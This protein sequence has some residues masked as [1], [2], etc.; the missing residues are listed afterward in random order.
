MLSG[1]EFSHVKKHGKRYTPSFFI[2]VSV[3]S[4]FIAH[5]RCVSPWYRMPSCL[6]R[7]CYLWNADDQS[8]TLYFVQQLVQKYNWDM[9]IC[10]TDGGVCKFHQHFFYELIIKTCSVCWN[11][12]NYYAIKNFLKVTGCDGYKKDFFR[13]NADELPVA[14]V[15]LQRNWGLFT[16]YIAAQFLW[17]VSGRVVSCA[18]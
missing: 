7:S 13:E 17:V 4:I 3:A 15:I 9:F 14:D 11:C 2:K 12:Y 1:K 8:S 18:C 5:Q 6:T 16:H 10:K